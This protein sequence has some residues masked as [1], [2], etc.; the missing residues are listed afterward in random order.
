MMENHDRT[1]LVMGGAGFLGRHATEALLESGYRVRVFDREG[2]ALENIVHLL[3]RVHL[4]LG[5]FSD[6]ACLSRVL[7]GA[8]DVLHLVGTTV[9]QTSNENPVYDVESNVIPT[10]RFLALA[11]RQGIRR[12]I[13]SSSGGTVYG[14]P[15]SVPIPESHPTEPICAYGISKLAIE[16]YLSLHSRLFGLRSVILRF[17]NPF[18]EG[19]HRLG[20][21]GAINVFL[22]R[23]REGKPVEIWG[24][25]NVV[26]D[27]VYARDIGQ[28]FVRAVETEAVDEVY[29]IGSGQGRS[30]NDLLA[31]FRETLG[32]KPEVRYLLSRPFDVPANILDIRKAAR[33]LPWQPSTP[34]EEG[35]RRTWE[36]IRKE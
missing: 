35:L 5:D 16:K 18:G 36:W 8:T 17:S 19:T 20:L 2:C 15:V 25:G 7:E 27:Y 28:S 26:R 32:L 29:N 24:D 10:L 3:P 33:L 13:F 9:A 14:I 23:L 1:C 22:R 6:E 4:T 34:F 30:L 31:S 12:V 21:Q 11:V